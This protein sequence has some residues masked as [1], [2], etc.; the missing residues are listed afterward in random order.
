MEFII[1]GVVTLLIISIIIG[2]GSYMN[3]N[4]DESEIEYTPELS[5]SES[6]PQS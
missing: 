5:D 1:S 4:E 2:I 3:S 6:E